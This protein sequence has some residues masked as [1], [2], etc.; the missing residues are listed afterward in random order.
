LKSDFAGSLH[1]GKLVKSI[2]NELDICKETRGI[3][4][5]RLKPLPVILVAFVIMLFVCINSVSALRSDDCSAILTWTDQTGQQQVQPLL[6]VG[7]PAYARILF[8]SNIAQEI[9][10]TRIGVN[11]DW[12]PPDNFVGINLEGNPAYV[13]GMGTY[14]N[15]LKIDVPANVSSGTHTYY[16]GIEGKDASGNFSWSSSKLTVEINN[17]YFTAAPTATP[18]GNG[19]QNGDQ[20]LLIYGAIA[21]VLVVIALL[22]LIIVV[23]KKKKPAPAPA[24]T[25]PAKDTAQPQEKTEKPEGEEY[26]I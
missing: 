10:I 23:R 9:E 7:I 18:T 22:L 8:G 26:Q 20:N 1:W 5:K 16:I 2:Y 15:L 3:W 19:D 13:Q 6:N 21:A 14:S 24:T 25:E 17:P 11:F 4:M 12:M